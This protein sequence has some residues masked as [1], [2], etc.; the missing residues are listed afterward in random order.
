MENNTETAGGKPE[1]FI[2]MPI[3]EPEGYKPGH[4]S[5]VYDQI[6][7]VACEKAGYRPIRADD[8]KQTNLIHLDMLQKLLEAPMAICD[9]STRNP[10]ALFELG[11]R[12]A[13]DKPVVLVQEIGTESIFDIAPL[14]Y[15]EYRNS[16]FYD[17][18][19]EDQER[20]AK[21]ITETEREFKTGQGVNSI[22]KLLALTKSAGLPDVKEAGNDPLLQIVRAELAQLRREV[23]DTLRMS[24]MSG[25][26]RHML[27]KGGSP[28]DMRLGL[29]GLASQLESGKHLL[30]NLVDGRTEDVADYE[31]ALFMMIRDIEDRF[32][33]LERMGINEAGKNLQELYEKASIDRGDLINDYESYLLNKE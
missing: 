13:F 6:F 19:L 11:I 1:C 22:V 16:L 4:F 15:T 3:S 7:K 32:F 18:V 12:Q 25:I 10:N 14:R 23:R 30:Q 2:L 8:V 9:L 24:E 21:S 5:R 17:E 20:I 27:T 28:N 29:K 33:K 26:E 31:K